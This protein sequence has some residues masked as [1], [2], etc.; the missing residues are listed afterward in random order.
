M[1]AAIVF[2]DE[3]GRSWEH[4]LRLVPQAGGATKRAAQRAAPRRT[5]ARPTPMP[6]PKPASK[7]N[8]DF[9]LPVR[10]FMKRY[11]AR[12]SGSRRFAILLAHMAKG[13]LSTPV[14]AADIEKQWNKM[15]PIMGGTAYNG[16]YPTRAKDSGWV[17]SA[18]SGSYVL[19]GE[20]KHALPD[21]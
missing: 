6:S 20:W 10:P 12:T 4:E 8:P 7:A 17:D 14:K 1:R 3:E 16:A 5:P 13:K 15:K 19:L 21:A 11:G 2:T 9:T 18:K